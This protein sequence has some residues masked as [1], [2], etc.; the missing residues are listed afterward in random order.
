MLP[1][2]L[3]TTLSMVVVEKEEE[4]EDYTRIVPLFVLCSIMGRWV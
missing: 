1:V 2:L 3:P 4:E